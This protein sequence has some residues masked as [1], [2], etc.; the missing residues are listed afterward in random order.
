MRVSIHR[1]A[2]GSRS[3]SG[4]NSW[5]CLPDTPPCDASQ[6]GSLVVIKVFALLLCGFGLFV[7]CFSIL[8]SSI[9]TSMAVATAASKARAAMALA[10]KMCMFRWPACA[11]AR[12]AMS[13]GSSS[14]GR[15]LASDRNAS[16]IT[17]PCLDSSP[18]TR[19]CC[20]RCEILRSSEAERIC[21]T[22][23]TPTTEA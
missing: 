18:R 8:S 3:H 15:S 19:T 5:C 17:H 7:H 1:E 10:S 22:D 2:G 11:H 21:S 9:F 13:V 16:T 14:S 23:P 20:R 12:H 4:A 6:Y